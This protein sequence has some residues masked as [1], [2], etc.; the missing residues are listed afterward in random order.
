MQ[1]WTVAYPALSPPWRSPYLAL[2]LLAHLALFA[3]LM[4]AAPGMPAPGASPAQRAWIEAS[5][6]R[7]GAAELQKHVGRL[8]AIRRELEAGMATP[9]QSAG[10]GDA[11]RD[12]AALAARARQL[13]DAIRELDVAARAKALATLLRVPEAEARARLQAE[14]GK[15]AQARAQ[16]KREIERQ[17]E[18]AQA[19]LQHARDAASAQ[20]DGVPVRPDSGRPPAAAGPALRMAKGEG[21]QAGRAE[22]PGTG[23]GGSGAASQGDGKGAAR[24]AGLDGA[25]A[26]GPA[27]SAIPLPDRLGAGATP[28][29]PSGRGA[30]P[31]VTGALHKARGATIGP[32][33]AFSNRLL[34]DDWQV[35]GPFAGR[36]DRNYGANPAYA[37]ERAVLLD[38]VYEGKDGRLL[39]WTSVK[40]SAY[41]L[42]PPVLAEDAVY[43]AYTE[44]RLDRDRDLWVWLGA[45][46]HAR[47]WVNDEL[48]YAGA[49]DNKLWFFAQV[50]GADQDRLI[51]DWNMTEA[52]RPVHFRK[53]VNRLL[54]KLSNGPK[55]VF[56]SVLLTPG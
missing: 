44:V 27:G 33:G 22:A 23:A 2:S 12:P 54:L 13:S 11:P 42:S 32:G 28:F 47:L 21:K 49:A 24:G 40:G 26:G 1:S 41:P 48:A 55:H 43:Y 10:V 17:A 31:A 46:D 4:A 25:R 16:D 34:L 20:R 37:P 50:H 15:P 9:R 38:A 30:I 35:I 56:F 7:T 51:Q 3:G 18:Q 8:E 36:R 5:L 45:D 6:Q 19:A 52:R 29:G 14:A 39:A 53:G